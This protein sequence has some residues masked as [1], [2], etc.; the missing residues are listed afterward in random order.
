MQLKVDVI[1]GAYSQIKIS[2]I[3]VKPTPEEVELALSRLESMMHEFAS[4]NID[5]GY[6]FE[7]SPDPSSLT[8]ADPSAFYMMQ[9]NLAVRLVSDYGK[10]APPTLVSGAISSLSSVSSS[11][12]RRFVKEVSYPN[13]MARGS[14]NTLRYNRWARFYRDPPEAPSETNTN[15]LNLGDV[16]S[17]TES[18]SQYLNEGENIDSYIITSDIELT[19]SNDSNTNTA[20]NYTVTVDDS[21]TTTTTGFQRVVIQITTTDSR[22]TSR[23]INF[24]INA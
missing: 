4:R 23:Q 16:N 15:V 21:L 7:E 11:S 18:F 19:I 24:K 10:N 20:I 9:S 2:G 3:T 22:V 5:V 1:N 12:A 6:N 8:N 13:R 17:Y 14:G